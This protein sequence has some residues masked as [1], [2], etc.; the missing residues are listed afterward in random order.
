MAKTLTK[1]VLEALISDIKNKIVIKI[2]KGL[3]SA[4][5]PVVHLKVKYNMIES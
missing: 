2:N 4:R 5:T 3:G 1:D